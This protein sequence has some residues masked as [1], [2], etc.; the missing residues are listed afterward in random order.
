M[1]KVLRSRP[2]IFLLFK[3]SAKISGLFIEL[4]LLPASSVQYFEVKILFKF[5]QIQ[6]SKYTIIK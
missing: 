5:Q 3:V 6:L 2:F 1:K 4:E